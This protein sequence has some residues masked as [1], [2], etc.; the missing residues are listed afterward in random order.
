MK[1]SLLLLTLL[2]GLLIGCGPDLCEDVECGPGVC[3][4]G[5]CD[6]PDG[7]SG[8]NCERELCFGVD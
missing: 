3:V 6:C 4:E 5:I 1:K 2:L 8:D 7:F